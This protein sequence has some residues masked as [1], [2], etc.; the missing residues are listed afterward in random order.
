MPSYSPTFFKPDD[1][2][3]VVPAPGDVSTG[4]SGREGQ[5]FE[6]LDVK[7]GNSTNGTPGGTISWSF[8]T[9]NLGIEPNDFTFPMPVFFQ[10]EV[11]AAFDAWEAVANISFVEVADGEGVNIRVGMGILDGPL[12]SGSGSTVG[13]AFYSFSQGSFIQAH[14]V[15]DVE[16]YTEVGD[17]NRFFLT[18]VHEIGHAIGLGHENDVVS[19]MSAFINNSLS[20]PTADDIDGVQL[21]YGTTAG[22]IDDVSPDGVGTDGVVAAPGW[23]VGT[24][25]VVGD[26]DWFAVTLV[27]GR[28]YQFDLTAS[29]LSDPFLEL[30]DSSGV[31]VTSNDDGGSGLNSQITYTATASGTFY[32][33]VAAFENIGLIDTGTYTLATLD[34]GV[35]TIPGITVSEGSTDTPG[36][37]STSDTLVSGDTFNGI[38]SST[39]DRDWVSIDLTAGTEYTF[40]LQGAG[41]GTGTLS[42]PFLVLRNSSGG[43]V[44]QDDDSGAGLDA[45]IVYTPI[46][47]G[48]FYISAR[49]F[50]ASGG[51][52]DLV[53]SPEERTADTSTTIPGITVAEGTMDVPGSAATTVDLI[54]GDTFEGELDTGNDRDWVR[55]ELTSGTEYTFDLEGAD[56]GAGTL[57]DPFLVL[58]DSSGGF[59]AQNDDSGAGLNSQIVFTPSSSGT[60]YLAARN[61]AGETGTYVL[62]TSP[63]E[64]T[65][66]DGGGTPDP[67]P[68]P[69]PSPGQ[70]VTEGD[71]DAAGDTSTAAQ[72]TAGDTFQGELDAIGDR[73]FVSI[74]LTAGTQYTFGLGGADS[75]TGT[76]SDPFLVLRDANGTFVDQDDNSGTGLDSQIVFT[77]STSGTFFLSVRNFTGDTGTYELTA[78]TGS[79]AQS[80]QMASGEG[81][82]TT[83][84][85]AEV[86]ALI[87]EAQVSF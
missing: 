27:E 64:R 71:T 3:V 25:N 78:T 24:I 68:D 73:D 17:S 13:T 62:N 39:S 6:L 30:R 85:A 8:A 33:V 40:D 31:F 23:V 50:G 81:Y 7:W 46:S 41:A 4:D 86:L 18:T 87:D 14:V 51:T 76:L 63:E 79:A 74:D 42:D 49:T 43:F 75:S 34:L 72:F 29:T 2:P 20:G 54:S 57:T 16:D 55:I 60:Y 77:P 11:R 1:G 52:Y 69:D 67:D 84:S 48:T 37:V 44:S 38:L 47:S 19:I 9:S 80:S 70:T 28:Q 10:D 36:S 53:T 22:V 45:Q 56:S 59:V 15:L 61:F 26:E 83:I 58:R 12:Q 32:L 82:V 5:S 65:D 35:P 21:I 66:S